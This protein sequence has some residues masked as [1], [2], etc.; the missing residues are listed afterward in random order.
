VLAEY[1]VQDLN[2]NPKL[3]FDDNSFDL[4][5]LSGNEEI[6]V[7]RSET[8]LILS[9][10]QSDGT[11]T[12][13][14]CEF[15][16][17]DH[18]AEEELLPTF[19]DTSSALCEHD[20][21]NDNIKFFDAPY[22]TEGWG[23]YAYFQTL[24]ETRFVRRVNRPVDEVS[25]Q[26][27]AHN[28]HALGPTNLESGKPR[29]HDPITRFGIKNGDKVEKQCAHFFGV[30]ISDEQA[31]SRIFV[32]V[33]SAAQS[34]FKQDSGG[35]YSIALQVTDDMKTK[36]CADRAGLVSAGE[37]EVR[38]MVLSVSKVEPPKFEL[39]MGCK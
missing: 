27:V 20:T 19:P 38:G 24:E 35:G 12:M 17:Y 16:N 4:I 9:E 11:V 13:H 2:V 37:K 1:L 21:S 28:N 18:S 26:S 36:N 6:L 22:H 34:K 23:P 39:Q 10:R 33:T 14:Y 25:T 30:T 8:K 7:P 3:P 5:I 15:D 31:Q 32:R 29:D